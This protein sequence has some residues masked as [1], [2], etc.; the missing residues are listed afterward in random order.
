MT[1]LESKLLAFYFRPL[2]PLLGTGAVRT[3]AGGTVELSIPSP[4]VDPSLTVRDDRFKVGPPADLHKL[5]MSQ[6]SD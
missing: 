3:S 2:S 4:S 1:P 6:M 5:Q